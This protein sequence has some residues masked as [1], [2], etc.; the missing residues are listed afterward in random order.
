MYMLNKSLDIKNGLPNLQYLSKIDKEPNPMNPQNT[1]VVSFNQ[2]EYYQLIMD[3]TDRSLDARRHAIEFDNVIVD[4]QRRNITFPVRFHPVD[5]QL[6]RLAHDT[7]IQTQNLTAIMREYAM[8][9]ADGYVVTPKTRVDRD[10]RLIRTKR[11]QVLDRLCELSGLVYRTRILHSIR[12]MTT[13]WKTN[14]FYTSLED[15]ITKIYAAA[16]ISMVAI[17]ATVSALSSVNIG[18]A[19]QTL[20]ILLNMSFYRCE[21]E[22]IG[23]QTS[24][25]SALSAA[26]FLVL[27]PTDQDHME[28]D[29]FDNLCN[30]VF[31]ELIAWPSDLPSFVRRNGATN[32]FRVYVN[33]G[34][35]REIAA[36]M[37][38]VLLRRPWLPLVQSQNRYRQCHVLIPNVDPANINDQTYVM[39]NGFLNG[40]INASRRNPNPGRTINANSFRK[41]LKNLR[42]ICVS[43]LMPVIRLIK[44]NVE[45]VARAF[46]FLPYSADLFDINPELRDERLRIKLPISG[47][48]SLVMGVTKAPD[49]FDWSS[50]LKFA[51]N[52]RKLDYAEAD[53]VEDAAVIAVLKN[54]M[55]RTISK[56]ETLIN[57]IK[58]PTPTIAAIAK[59]PSAALTSIFSDRQL[60]NLIRQTD[61]YTIITRIMAILNAAFANVPTSHH[62]IGKGA[63]LNPI[64]APFGRSSQYVR[65][66]NVIFHRPPG[67]QTFTIQQLMNGQYFQGLIAQIRAR[68]PVFIE[69][70]IQLRVAHAN[71]I[72]QITTA[73]LTMNSPYDSFINPKDLQQQRMIEPREVDLY[74]DEETNRPNDEFENV[75]S[76]TSVYILDAQRMIV[77]VQA[78]TLN[79]AYHDIMI[80][81]SVIPYLTFTIAQPPDLQ[82]FNGLLVFEQ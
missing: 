47:A 8:I 71:D 67:V 36:Y 2:N 12:I 56:K 34:V 60:I 46:Q 35:N 81:D 45:R 21:I 29:V 9:A 10:Q 62:G 77:P 72:E 51:D 52:V 57:S 82:L 41:L 64:P 61:S 49:P 39:L 3:R 25:G 53:A 74:I 38:F 55:D 42:D 5:M 22:L 75:M 76:R 80:S 37:R 40:I 63:L 19:K 23:S 44:Y 16:E 33:A 79:F 26:I 65:R 43:R 27:L 6:I 28:E 31:N 70:P 24:F 66:D 50:I 58:P 17:D 48:L 32:A 1:I 59:I 20:D 13:L 73:Y 30:L 78:Q 69:G 68:R 11:S 15:E 18:V 4:A 7:A 54:D 14:V